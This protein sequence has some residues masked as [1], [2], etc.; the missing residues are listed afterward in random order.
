MVSKIPSDSLCL[1][2]YLYILWWLFHSNSYI[3]LVSGLLIVVI[4]LII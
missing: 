1:Q 2:L 4:F 3:A